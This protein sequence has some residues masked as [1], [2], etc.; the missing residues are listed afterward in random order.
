[1]EKSKYVARR[2]DLLTKTSVLLMKFVFVRRGSRRAR[3]HFPATV[4]LVSW[5][6]DAI[7]MSVL[8]TR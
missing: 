8:R 6:S 4:T 2:C 5:P 3:V 1:M 7:E